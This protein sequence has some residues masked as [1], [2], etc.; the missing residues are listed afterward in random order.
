MGLACRSLVENRAGFLQS[1]G[2]TAPPRRE[3][4][5]GP[6]AS[7]AIGI[8]RGRPPTGDRGALKQNQEMCATI[9]GVDPGRTRS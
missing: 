8:E 7:S 4:D 9:G 1:A 3:E 6:R 2:T 5:S